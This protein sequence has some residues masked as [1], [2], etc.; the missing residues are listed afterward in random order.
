MHEPEHITETQK[1]FIADNF[2][3]TE[4]GL[5]RTAKN[6]GLQAMSDSDV[7]R[8]CHKIILSTPIQAVEIR[9]KN[10][11]FNSQEYLAVLTINKSSLGIITAKRYR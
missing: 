3:N 11:Y 9:G 8:H 6:L 4:R 7:V 1:Q 2:G 5:V 10:Y